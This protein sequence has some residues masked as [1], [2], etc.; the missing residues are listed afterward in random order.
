MIVSLAPGSEPR[1]ISVVNQTSQHIELMWSPPELSYGII[2][3]Y[4]I[5]FDFNNGTGP[6][7]ATSNINQYF[8]SSLQPYQNVSVMISATNSIGSGPFSNPTSFTTNESSKT[9]QNFVIF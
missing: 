6:N 8:I 3:N 4:T 7:I 1:D 2:T 5:R 9:A